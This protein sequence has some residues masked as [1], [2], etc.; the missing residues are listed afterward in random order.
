VLFWALFV[1]SI[2]V[3]VFEAFLHALNARYAK[4]GLKRYRALFLRL[5]A[6]LALVASLLAWRLGDN[7]QALFGGF[8]AFFA[9]TTATEVYCLGL[10]HGMMNVVFLAVAFVFIVASHFVFFHLMT[11]WL[12]FLALA[13]FIAG[14]VFIFAKFHFRILKR[15]VTL[16]PYEHRSGLVGSAFS[17]S[18]YMI[19]SKARLGMNAMLIGFLGRKRLLVT[20]QL[21]ARLSFAEVEGIFLHEEGHETLKHLRMRVGYFSVAL[22]FLVGFGFLSRL[23]PGDFYTRHLSALFGYY[24][25]YQVF[26]QCLIRLL[27]RQEYA[28]DAYAK[29]KGR[30]MALKEGLA[31]IEK[32][33]ETSKIHPAFARLYLSHPRIKD[34]IERL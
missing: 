27:H 8:I 25:I 3:L 18:V 5:F 31:K 34:R 12:F 17:E 6:V 26:Q 7:P 14:A 23:L 24:L 22:A 13:V 21:L 10:F 29:R 4:E 15:R 9:L 11:P 1:L 30:A 33:V 28:S 20:P 16:V 32:T 2:A 19:V